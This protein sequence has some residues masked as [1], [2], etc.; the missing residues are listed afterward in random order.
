MLLGGVS[1]TMPWPRLNTNG[2]VPQARSRI[3][4][5]PPLKLRSAGDA[6][7]AD[8]DC[9]A[10][11]GG[12]ASSRRMQA[13]GIAGVAAYGVDAGLPAR[14]R[15]A[16]APHPRG[17]P[18]IG[19][20]GTPMPSPAA[21]MAR[22]RRMHQRANSSSAS[23]PAQL[24]KIC[25]TS[26]PAFD[27]AEQIVDRS[28]DQEIDQALE[29][30][31]I[32]IGPEPR[33]GLVLAAAALD[34]VGRHRPRR[35]AKA[36]QRHVFRQLRHHAAPQSRRPGRTA[37]QQKSDRAA[38]DVLAVPHRLELRPFALDELNL[39][40]ERIR[41]RSRISEKTIAASRSNRRSGCSV[42]SA[43]SAGLR[44]RSRKEPAL[45][46]TSRYSGR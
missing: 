45:A 33:L 15:S 10:P 35:P 22:S 16:N 29:R 11:A 23:L 1:G 9:P 5:T 7:A 2:R 28:V 6:G 14:R 20:C 41:A 25:S 8:R 43:A 42:T 39:L 36:D 18:M 46:R 40:P 38:P 13:S 26:A 37:L 30:G 32:A 4:S 44:Q 34:H 27:L 12:L 24:S 3:A 17:K 31:G 19:T 21:T